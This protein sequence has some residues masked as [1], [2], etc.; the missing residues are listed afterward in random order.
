[1]GVQILDLGRS[2]CYRELSLC[3]KTTDPTGPRAMLHSKQSHHKE[4][5]TPKL[6]EQ[7]LATTV[8]DS[9][10]TKTE[11]AAKGQKQF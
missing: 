3:T 5:C 1:M 4:L 7:P 10:A 2:I 6:R 8:K 11:S 9:T